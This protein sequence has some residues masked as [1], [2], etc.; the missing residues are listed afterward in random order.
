MVGGNRAIP[1]PFSSIV[2]CL[3]LSWLLLRMSHA[4]AMAQDP[5]H[6]VSHASFPYPNKNSVKEHTGRADCSQNFPG[7]G[8]YSVDTEG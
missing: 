2:R 6:A 7:G 8:D 1:D 5:E 3:F 4:P